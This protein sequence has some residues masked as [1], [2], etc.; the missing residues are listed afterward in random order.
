MNCKNRFIVS[1]ILLAVALTVAAGCDPVLD[2]EGRKVK[3]SAVSKASLATKTAY[4][5][6]N[7]GF[8]IIGWSENDKIRIYSPDTNISVENNGSE[9]NPGNSGNVPTDATWTPTDDVFGLNYWFAD[10]TVDE[11]TTNGH[12]SEATLKNVGGNGL[13]WT[14]TGNAT[15]YAAYPHAT[16]IASNNASQLRFAPYVTPTQTGDSTAVKDMPLLA[17][18][19][20]KSTDQDK[21][22]KLDFYPAFSTFDLHFKSADETALTINSVELV[23]EAEDSEKMFLTGY[24]YYDL[25]AVTPDADDSYD[26]HYLANSALSFESASKSLKVTKNQAATN[27]T[28][29]IYHLFTL[30]CNLSKLSLKVTFT[31]EGGTATTKTLKLQYKEGSIPSG[32]TDPWV[33]FPAGHKARI[34]GL[35]MEGGSK[36]KLTIDDQVLPWIEDEQ[37]TS[38]RNN[39]GIKDRTFS[40]YAEQVITYEEAFGYDKYYLRLTVKIQDVSDPCIKYTFTPTAPIGGYWQLSPEDVIPGSLN[41]FSIKVD[42]G[43]NGESERLRGQVMGMPVTIFIRPTAEYLAMDSPAPVYAILIHCNMSPS[44]TFDPLYSADSEFQG[45]QSDGRFSYYKFRIAK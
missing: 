17:M 5:E 25:N 38:F 16:A 11:I 20:I 21:A 31:P 14:G 43:I 15:F 18:K 6:Y 26:S 32:Q 9:G 22:V 45:G 23:T 19:T 39:I 7:G 40:G 44:I 29:A 4:G 3:F 24:C 28:E 2:M 12:K 10:Y 34:V 30:P 35:A 8:Q 37:T 36:W 42:D 33:H 41:Y 1:T 13:T 27:A